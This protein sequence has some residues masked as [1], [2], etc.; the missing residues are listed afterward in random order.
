MAQV[1]RFPCTPLA[2]AAGVAATTVALSGSGMA[3]LPRVPAALLVRGARLAVRATL[4]ASCTT[5]G[6]TATIGVYLGA[7]NS[8]IASKI[9]VALTGAMS[10][11]TGAAAWPALFTYDG[12]FRDLSPTAGVIHGQ[13]T[14]KSGH[15]AA[16]GG[17]SAALVEFPLPVT[18]ALRT[19]STLVTTTDLEVDIG[20]AMS[21]T[22][23]TPSL[24]VTDLWA[25]LS[26]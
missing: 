19:V 17:L 16:G 12:T 20:I 1:W 11:A 2:D 8:A 22:T 23:G 7:P 25:E 6:S 13:G 5:T 24:T 21:A 9:A 26:G 4:E 3:K 18:A 15:V 14:Y 10:F